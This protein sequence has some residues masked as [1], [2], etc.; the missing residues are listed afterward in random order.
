MTMPYE[1]LL[2]GLAQNIKNARNERGWTQADM[3]EK[4]G[5]TLRYYQRLESGKYQPSLHTL[6][7]LAKIFKM[8][9]KDLLPD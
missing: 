6:H 1:K 4:A 8:N 5:F 9:V 7:R 2:N 3:L